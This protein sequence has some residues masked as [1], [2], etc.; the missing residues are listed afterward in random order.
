MG[1]HP[2]SGFINSYWHGYN[3]AMILLIM[4]IGAPENA[5]PASCWDAWTS[6]YQWDTFH[7]YEHVNFGPLFGHQYSHIFIDFR[8]IAD[9]YMREKGIDYFENSRRATLSQRTYCIENPGKFTG[10]D[11][12][13]WGLTACDGPG[14]ARKP[15]NGKEITF[16][17]YAA[18]G[19][20]T[21]YR[22]D[23]GTIAPTAAGGSIPFA[24]EVCIPA[25]EAMVMRY[26]EHIYG[27]FGFFDAFNPSFPGGKNSTTGWVDVDYLG[28]DQGP[29]ILM[30]A[31]HR[32]GL[33]WNLF[34]KN[35]HITGGL[36]KAGF[37][38]GWL[39]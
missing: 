28:I 10:Y 33:I 36:K 11:S 5:I 32:N 35:P 21:G 20:A 8:G 22:V 2:E 17:G 38:G 15:F 24:P 9:R 25:L 7:G 1:W 31:N 29:I 26:G 6:T 14:Y 3:E 27:D 30:I 34:K 12:L 39:E 23:D 4:A 37:S 18:R 19:A 16:E 13:V